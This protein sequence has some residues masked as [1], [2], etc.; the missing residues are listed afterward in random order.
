MDSGGLRKIRRCKNNQNGQGLPE[1][2]FERADY[3]PFNFVHIIT[4][5]AH[6][7]TF[8]L[9]SKKTK[10][11][12]QDFRIQVGPQSGKDTDFASAQDPVAR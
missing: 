1:Y 11:Q 8:A 6:Q 3:T 12:N 2:S 4:H 5:P 10:R 9:F 7:V